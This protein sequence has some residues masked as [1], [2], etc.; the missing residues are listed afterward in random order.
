M[1]IV[2]SLRL[3]FAAAV[4]TAASLATTSAQA[5]APLKIGYTS[6]EYVLSQMPESKQIESDL[7]A[8]NS[9]LEAQL[10]SKYT[11]YQTKGEA[12]QKGAAT[13]TDVVKADKEKELT[14][15]QQSIQEFQR[16]AEQSL[17]QKQQTLLKPAL[18]KL[19]KNIDA[20]AE[21]N[22]YTYVLNSDGASP[23]LLHGPKDGDIS[24][25]VLKKMGITPGANTVKQ[26]P[27]A[28]AT[29]PAPAPAGKTKTKT[30]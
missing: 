25:L 11:E 1:N 18:D 17:Q 2:N 6:V 10:K 23:V 12:Y 8:Y 14:A 27:V 3:T 30:K 20:V 16:N 15:L 7:K 5:Q 4:L 21:E 28:P 9:Q 22:G 13:M 19:Q 26:A 24:D 29:A